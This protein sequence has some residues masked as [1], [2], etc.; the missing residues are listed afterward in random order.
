MGLRDMMIEAAGRPMEQMSGI[1]AC[2]ESVDIS[3]PYRALGI[4]DKEN[5]LWVPDPEAV[6]HADLRKV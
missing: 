3:A 4:Q 5:E 2:G 1:H 6:D